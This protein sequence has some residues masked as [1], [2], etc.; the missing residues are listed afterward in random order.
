MKQSLKIGAIVAAV[1]LALFMLVGCGVTI[2]TGPEDQGRLAEVSDTRASQIR[3][4]YSDQIRKAGPVQKAMI[5]KTLIDSV[6]ENYFRYGERLANEW[7]TANDSRGSEV[8]DTEM[9]DI[10]TRSNESQ[11]AIFGAY[12]DVVDLAMDEITRES[13]LDR[14]T[15]E[16]LENFRNQFYK[17][18]SA[19][20]YPSISARHYQDEIFNNRSETEKQS[21]ELQTDLRR[22]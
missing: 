20:F 16:L 3:G 5:L 7:E 2:R 13:V 14:T 15:V 10:V 12:E 8:P 19:T 18:H 11:K 22:Y 4:E 17:N 1:S 9:R 21:R 6:S